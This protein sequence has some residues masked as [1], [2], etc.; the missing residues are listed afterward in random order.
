MDTGTDTQEGLVENPGYIS[1][2]L[3]LG[4]VCVWKA[5]EFQISL[6]LPPSYISVLCSGT[7]CNGCLPSAWTRNSIQA[8]WLVTDILA[9]SL[10]LFFFP[11][12]DIL[13][14]H[15]LIVCLF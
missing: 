3:L 10:L 13:N 6:S 4:F 8:T 11:S 14:M 12:P 9:P 15:L 7:L 5:L 2:G 1:P